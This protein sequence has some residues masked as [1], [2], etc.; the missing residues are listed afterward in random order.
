MKIKWYQDHPKKAK[1]LKPI[2]R[3]QVAQTHMVQHH[4]TY[5]FVSTGVSCMILKFYNKR[6]NPCGT[7]DI[8]VAM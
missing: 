8:M 2:A 6:H 4:R 7:E 1:L 5:K 3:Q